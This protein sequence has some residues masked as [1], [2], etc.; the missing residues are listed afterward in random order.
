MG[1]RRR[2]N[3][4]PSGAVN[5]RRKGQSMNKVNEV[6]AM[7]LYSELW[8]RRDCATIGIDY[9]AMT[10]VVRK[11]IAEFYDVSEDKLREVEYI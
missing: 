1:D 6:I 11:V 2:I 3:I 8:E 9:E 5:L 7:A 4:K 10:Q